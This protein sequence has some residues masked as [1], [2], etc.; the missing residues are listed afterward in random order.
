[1]EAYLVEVVEL[2]PAVLAVAGLELLLSRLA[3]TQSCNLP[4]LFLRIVV[5]GYKAESFLSLPF[6]SAHG[7]YMLLVEHSSYVV[8]SGRIAAV[9]VCRRDAVL[10]EHLPLQGIDFLAVPGPRC[11]GG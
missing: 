6:R 1:M 10:L 2:L 4:S 9:R 5:L 11:R 8:H 3:S 7:R